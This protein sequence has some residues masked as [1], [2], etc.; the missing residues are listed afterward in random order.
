MSIFK[1]LIFPQ[2]KVHHRYINYIGWSFISN[3]VIST[4]SVLST[5]SMLSVFTGTTSVENSNELTASVNYIGKDIIGQ[6]GGLFIISSVSQKIDKNPKKFII[7]STICQQAATILECATPLLPIYTFIPI[8]S[9]ANI[10]KNIGF[11][12]F[13]AVNALVIQKLAQD[14]NI[15][16][17]YAKIS[18][19]NTLG[20]TIGMTLGLFIASK[21]PDHSM[22]LGIMPV[23]CFLRVYSYNKAIQ[24]L[25]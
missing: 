8:A 22:R 7:C 1:R 24:D 9:V 14:N 15:G 10:G 5:H 3:I 18:V 25:V 11:T 20:S 23:L 13:G 17:I 2:G 21:I 12:G 4:E 19:I 16:E 6:L